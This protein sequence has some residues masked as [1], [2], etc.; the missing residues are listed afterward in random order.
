MV[1]QA[2]SEFIDKYTQ[3]NRDRIIFAWNQKHGEEFN[4]SNFQFRQKVIDGV[5][6][7]PERANINLLRNLFEA[8]ARWSKEA[9]C[10]CDGFAQVGT[11]M[12]KRGG[13]DSLDHFLLWFS[14]SFD[15]FSECHT[16]QLDPA[17]VNML[18]QEINRRLTITSKD[19]DKSRL[20]MAKMLFEKYKTGNPAQGMIRLS[21]DTKFQNIR[22]V[23]KFEIWFDKLRSSLIRKR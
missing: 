8:E 2:V 18:L 12:L 9:W 10:V 11:L 7:A 16:M 20:E 1:E 5:I 4:D 19:S 14:N 15:A 17:T 23:S 21:A 6:A 3:A 13:I 22:A